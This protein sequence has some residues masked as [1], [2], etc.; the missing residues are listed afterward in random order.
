VPD[1]FTKPDG[2]LFGPFTVTGGQ[3]VG[4]VIVKTPANMADLA[5]QSDSIRAE[6]KQ[7][8]A[9]DRST[10]FE[11]G[12]KKRLVSEGKLKINQDV[13]TRLVQNYTNRS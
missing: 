3:I 6:L 9:A 7:K 11:Q 10:L 2:A 12:L 5:K 8:K 13:L 1:A 4:K